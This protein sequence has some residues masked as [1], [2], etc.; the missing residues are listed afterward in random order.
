MAGI[1]LLYTVNVTAVDDDVR[2]QDIGSH[3]IDSI[4]PEYS[5]HGSSRVKT[6]PKW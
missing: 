1:C 5:S 6:S 2:R 4:L 3:G